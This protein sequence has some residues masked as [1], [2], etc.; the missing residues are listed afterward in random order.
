MK[1]ETA[2]LVFKG[3]RRNWTDRK[4]GQTGVS[5]DYAGFIEYKGQLIIVSFQGDA[6]GR[7]PVYEGKSGDSLVYGRVTVVTHQSQRNL[8]TGGRR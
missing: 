8:K 7:V 5:T 2:K 6:D 3:K 1:N 4:T